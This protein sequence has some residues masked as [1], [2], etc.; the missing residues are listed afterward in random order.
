MPV[1]GGDDIFFDLLEKQADIAKEAAKQFSA[2]QGANGSSN[3]I[4]DT[5]KKL[6]AE[7]DTVTH[8]LTRRADEKFITPFDKE[9]M[10]SLTVA[11]DDVTDMIEAAG[12]RMLIYQL[13]GDDADFALLA[14]ALE[15]TVQATADSVCGLRNLKKHKE[16][17]TSLTKVHEYENQTDMAYR[18][19]LGKLFM[20][21]QPDPLE[22]F[23]WKDIYDHIEVAAD[24]C[25]DVAVFLE[26]V[27]VKYG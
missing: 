9:D 25:E 12:A 3:Q 19:A 11:L 4:V 26:K 13:H 17:Q 27:A 20:Q 16:L 24:K 2:F 8:D 6:E 18:D 10:H 7:G 22:V 5:L 14:G 21:K 15:K 1:F 23:K